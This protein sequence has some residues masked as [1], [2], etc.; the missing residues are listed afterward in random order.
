MSKTLEELKKQIEA[1]PDTGVSKQEWLDAGGKVET[2]FGVEQDNIRE[3][4]REKHLDGI[5]FDYTIMNTEGTFFSGDKVFLDWTEEEQDEYWKNLLENKLEE[6]FDGYTRSLD[7]MEKDGPAEWILQRM[8]PTSGLAQIYAESYSGKTICVVD[9]V[10]SMAVGKMWFHGT[11]LRTKGQPMRTLYI[12]AEGGNTLRSYFIGW[13]HGNPNEDHK[14]IRE[15]V[16]IRDG[17]KGQKVLMSKDNLK[18][19]PDSE[20]YEGSYDEMIDYITYLPKEKRPHMVVFDTQIDLMSDADE[21]NN[22]EYGRLLG[23]L[24]MDSST[25][26]M[27]FLLVH[28][29]GH[30]DGKSEKRA[31]GASAQKSKMDSLLEL[32]IV[33]EPEAFRRE[34]KAHKVKGSTATSDKK[35]MYETKRSELPYVDEE[36]NFIIDEYGDK[37][38]YELFWAEDID[39]NDL[40]GFFKAYGPPKLPA[41]KVRAVENGMVRGQ[42]YSLSEIASLVDVGARNSQ[43]FTA[44]LE[45]LTFHGVLREVASKGRTRQFEL[46]F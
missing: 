8:L 27:L 2:I 24:Q 11:K 46:S 34:I 17:G 19:L 22:T 33:G 3:L 1:D 13:E 23:R 32:A 35:V 37:E 18:K 5:V 28:H 39:P 9:L 31:R 43:K 41:E 10:C 38:T 30:N 12:G 6:H 40:E 4:R 16:E 29:T 15:N 45:S 25:L 44:A 20:G 42:K 26:G 36:G 14:L 7:D 21:N